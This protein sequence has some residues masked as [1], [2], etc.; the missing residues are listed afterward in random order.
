M[1][2]NDFTKFLRCSRQRRTVPQEEK[3]S[4][5]SELIQMCI[6]DR[7]YQCRKKYTDRGIK[8]N[9]IKKYIGQGLPELTPVEIVGYERC[10]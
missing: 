7:G 5:I 2:Y 4:A 9:S 8:T 10:V 1:S 6:R 3:M